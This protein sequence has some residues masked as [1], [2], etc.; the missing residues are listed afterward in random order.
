MKN[1]KWLLSGLVI[2]LCMLCINCQS[3]KSKGQ[4]KYPVKTGNCTLFDKSLPEIK[5]YIHG[6]WELVSGGNSRE[7]CEYENTF[8][9]FDGD[10]YIWTEDDKEEPGNLNW[11]KAE[12][13]AGYEAYLMDVFYAEHP[14]YPLAINGDTLY[15]QDCSET[16]YKYTLVRK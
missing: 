2:C 14:A 13:G 11:R 12:T 8:I 3:D 5:E 9:E 4:K 1:V 6:E 7:L 15:I 16:A 10:K